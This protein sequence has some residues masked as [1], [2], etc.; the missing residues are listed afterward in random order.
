MKPPTIP[1]STHQYATDVSNRRRTG[2][3]SI[4]SN[5]GQEPNL[6][7][8][9]KVAIVCAIEFEMNA[10]RYMLDAEHPSLPRKEGDSNIYILGELKH[11]NIVLACLP[12]SQ[13]KGSAAIVVTHLVRT[14]PCIEWRFM[15]GIGG[16][17][18]STKHDIRLGDVVVSMPEGRHG[19]VV[20]YDLGRGT[21]EKFDRKGFLTPPP[22]L[23]RSAVLK[24]RSDH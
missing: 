4:I 8:K 15:V 6:F 24:M 7:A 20:Q 12:G 18:P 23:P 19:G 10:F 5:P 1:K 9:Y 2:S 22:P 3:A 14:F 11:H 17:V 13:V 21:C 16:G